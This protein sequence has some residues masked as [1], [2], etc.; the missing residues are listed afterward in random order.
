MVFVILQITCSS[1]VLKPW[2]GCSIPDS[3]S[4]IDVYVDY[5]SGNLD[6]DQPI[7]EEYRNVSAVAYV[8]GNRTD[9][10]WVDCSCQIGEGVSLG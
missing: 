10:I 2:Y 8:G 9:M 3:R 1:R 4:L 5:N 6:N 7:W